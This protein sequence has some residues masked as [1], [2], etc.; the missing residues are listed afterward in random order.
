MGNIISA[1]LLETKINDRMEL[2]DK[3]NIELK[4]AALQNL[5]DTVEALWDVFD[6]ID[7]EAERVL[8]KKIRDKIDS[9]IF[10]DDEN[11]TDEMACNTSRIS[12]KDQE[13]GK[14]PLGQQI[15]IEVP[16]M[17]ICGK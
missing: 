13:N 15:Y 2:V 17:E 10:S 11:K 1:E 16:E 14:G 9:I 8:Q 12:Q 7:F 5:E 4:L 3:W 6:L